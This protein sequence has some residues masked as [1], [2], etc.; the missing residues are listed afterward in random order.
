M[1]QREYFDVNEVSQRIN[2]Q[3]PYFAFERLWQDENS[4]VGNFVA[5]QPL[6]YEA[7]P[8]TAGELG[9]HLAILGSCT[10][11]ALHDGPEAYYLATKAHFTRK[12]MNEISSHDIYYASAQVINIDRRTLQVSAQ[13]WGSEAVAEL[14]CDYV[15][16]SPALFKRNFKHYVSEYHLPPTD[17]PYQHSIALHNLDFHEA[18]LDADAGPLSPMQCAG[19]FS[20]YPCW[21]VAIISQTVFQVTGELLKK[22]FGVNVRFHVQNTRLS[23]EKLVGADTVLRFNVEITEDKFPQLESVTRVYRDDE[24]VARLTNV[25]GLVFSLT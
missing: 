8:V 14:I 12:S 15:I 2:I 16:L 24:E 25:L 10:A 20:L 23:A 6:M 18:G 17:S 7:G 4:L 21:P 19:H 9:R 1:Q 22:K 13:A 5:E 3:R 11:V